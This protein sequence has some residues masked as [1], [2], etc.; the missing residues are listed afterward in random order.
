ML[1]YVFKAKV[2]KSSIRYLIYPPKEYQEKLKKLH[3]KEISVIVIEES[4]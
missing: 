2:V 3:G 4:D 1:I